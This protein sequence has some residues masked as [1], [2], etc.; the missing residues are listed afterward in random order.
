MTS[1]L[2]SWLQGTNAPDWD[3]ISSPSH[4]RGGNSVQ[5]CKRLN[6]ASTEHRLALLVALQPAILQGRR[7]ANEPGKMDIWVQVRPTNGCECLPYDLQL[8]ILDEASETVMQA[9][10]RESKNIQFEFSGTLGE[11]FSI[12]VA[13]GDFSLTET[14]VV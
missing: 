7:Y 3:A 10:A 6:L 14:F 8:A 4:F 1:H 2:T 5:R 11:H 13:F 12:R 9:I